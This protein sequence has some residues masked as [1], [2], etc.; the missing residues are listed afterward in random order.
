ME[1]S[2]TYCNPIS[3]EALMELSNTYSQACF[4]GKA[5]VE[6]SRAMLTADNPAFTLGDVSLVV[7]GFIAYLG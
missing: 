6:R 7:P 2:N 4:S 5:A 1:L 3:N